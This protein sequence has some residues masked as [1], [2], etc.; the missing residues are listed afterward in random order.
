MCAD[1]D[2]L[3][4][5]FLTMTR[6]GTITEANGIFLRTCGIDEQII[7]STPNLSSIFPSDRTASLMGLIR[8]SDDGESEESILT[9]FDTHRDHPVHWYQGRA[10][11]T[12]AGRLYQFIGEK[13]PAPLIRYLTSLKQD[14]LFFDLRN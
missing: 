7:M 4:V 10:S 9:I 2:H 8:E 11:G 12:Q 3:Q 6:E 14:I 5:P 13:E 1:R